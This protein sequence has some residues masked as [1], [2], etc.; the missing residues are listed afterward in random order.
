MINERYLINKIIGK[1]RSQVF[2][3]QDIEFPEI[4]RVIKLLPRNA[5]P[6][7]IKL[8]RNEFFIL[9]KLNHPN[10]IKANDFGTVLKTNGEPEISVG[11]KYLIMEYFQGEELINYKNISDEPALREIIKQIS[12][13]LYYLHQ[14]NYVYYDL[15]PE[16]ILVNESNGKPIIKLIDLGFAQHILESSE[17]TIRGTAEYIA[18]EIIKN[19]THDHRVDLYSLGIMLY[20]IVYGKFPFENNSELEIYKSHL[21]MEYEFPQSKYSDELIGAIK[22]LLLKNPDERFQNSLQL[23][24]AINIIIDEDLTKDWMPAKVF[25]NRKDT[26]TII[27]TYFAD[28]TSGEVFAIKSF[29]GAGK[30]AL[31]DEIYFQYDNVILIKNNKSKTG[32]DFVKLI[33]KEIVFSEFVFNKLSSEILARVYT[34]FISPPQDI[35]SEL[36]AIF[37]ALSIHHNFILLLDNFNY[38]DEFTVEVFKN[39]I[40]LLQVNR[41]RI[42]LT[43]TS[44]T[45][46]L[47]SFIFNLRELNLNPFT[48][49]HLDE[50]L[51]KSFY[52]D[53]PIGD[54]KKLILL[55]ADLLPGSIESF[56]RDIILLKIIQF[57]P[58]GVGI[59]TKDEEISVLKSSQ[60]EIYNFR[61]QMLSKSEEEIAKLVSAFEITV[62]EPTISQFVKIPPIQIPSLISSLQNKNIIQ[63]YIRSSGIFFISEGLKKF[64]YSKIDD[65]KNYHKLIAKELNERFPSYNRTEAARH[66]ELAGDFKKS[67]E[68]YKVELD[69]AEKITAYSY[70]KNILLH[71][72][73][74]KLEDSDLTEIKLQLCKVLYKLGDYQKSLKV[75]DELLNKTLGDELQ[76]ELLILKGNNQIGIGENEDGRNILTSLI[77]KIKDESRKQS[78]LVEIASAEFTLNNLESSFQICMQIVSNPKT[79]AE[80]KGKSYNLLGLIEIYKNNN[81]NEALKYI[82]QALEVYQQKNNLLRVAIMEMNMGNIF[83]MKGEHEKAEQCWNKSLETNLAIG[84]LEQE[85]MLLQNFGVSN[86]DKSNFEKAIE[87][88]KKASIIFLSLGNK[89]G[90]ASVQTNLGEIYLM[91]CEYQI[92]YDSLINSIN[93]FSQLHYTLEELET[94][95]TFANLLYK[96]GDYDQFSKVIETFRHKYEKGDINEKNKIQFDYLIELEKIKNDLSIVDLNKLHSLQIKFLDQIDKTDYFEITIWLVKYL[97]SQNKFDQALDELSTCQVSEFCYENLLFS[98]ERDYMLGKISEIGQNLQLKTSIEYY[99]SAFEAIKDFNVTELTWK[100]MF[101][102]GNSF[103]QRGNFSKAKENF[104]YSKEIIFYFGNNIKNSRLRDAYFNKPERKEA[105]QKIEKLGS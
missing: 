90:E 36:K 47:S 8:F 86:Y 45:N 11:S 97:L 32:F 18:P 23:L 48:E 98:V 68:I 12:S 95:F 57:T 62:D 16:N 99:T 78:L 67:Y 79:N 55:H 59:K 4:N 102:L 31:L 81:F 49:T 29:E 3:C 93:I 22:K 104:N 30:T 71:L 94:Q 103:F 56:L 1:G 91:T 74:L 101:D 64:V 51:T 44:N 72:L 37:T 76:L 96:I 85:A 92:A 38:Y 83:N 42:I 28:E 54:L 15:K 40:P 50:Y 14:S 87:F 58:G 24:S 105:L 7:E 60:E 100:I 52:K 39:L 6:E 20:K 34:I 84:N 46:Y 2:L 53:F 27:K 9:M 77:S 43:E 17:G 80:E 89:N 69:S 33:L 63:Q 65:K 73:E 10:I 19:E 26:L 13:V 25:S 75:A 5:D 88:Y 82:Q 21:E 61:F 66:Y 70:Q 35:Y 41:I